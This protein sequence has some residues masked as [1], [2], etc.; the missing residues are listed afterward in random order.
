MKYENGKITL[1]E[2]SLRNTIEVEAKT[3]LVDYLHPERKHFGGP[4][5]FIFLLKDPN[6]EE[7]DR[8]I[9]FSKFFKPFPQ[10]D[11]DR[12]RYVRRRYGRFITEISALSRAKEAGLTHVIELHSEGVWKKDGKDF[13]YY[14]MEK[15]DSTLKDY[16]L[17]NPGMDE[18]NKLQLCVQLLEGLGE[19]HG[20]QVYHRDIKPENIFVLSSSGEEG[21]LVWK[22]AD[23][24]LVS[25]VGRG[26]HDDFGERIGPFGWISPEVMNKYLTEKTSLGF[27]CVIDNSS[28]V[29][30]L[31]NVFWFIYQ[32]NVPL[33]QILFDDFIAN[34]SKE[35]QTL[36]N[37]I[38]DMIQHSKARRNDLASIQRIQDRLSPVI[39]AVGL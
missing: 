33:G 13:P 35:K 23:L 7:P 1:L 9:K 5:S 19:L 21:K 14:V 24:G 17:S 18:Q 22:I 3:Y 20:I 2:D 30:Q 37:I 38:R 6:A 31:G 15:A 8:V 39:D 36:Y 25:T 10:G 11:G 28:D 34:I 12:I 26:S 16:V 32:G 29:F 4:N 27:D